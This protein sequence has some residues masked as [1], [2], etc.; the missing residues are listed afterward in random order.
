M[1]D[2]QWTIAVVPYYSIQEVF[3]QNDFNWKVTPSNRNT[4]EFKQVHSLVKTILT[5]TPKKT[6]LFDLE[7]N[8]KELKQFIRNNFIIGKSETTKTHIDKNNFI[9]IYNKWLE[10][11]KPTIA[12]NWELVKKSGIIDGYSYLADLLSRENETL[13]EKLF[14]LLRS[15]H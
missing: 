7:K 15:S 4:R 13:K 9:T 3:Y 5:E 12:V 11:V 14:V 8:E 1:T 2:I 6:Y 10:V